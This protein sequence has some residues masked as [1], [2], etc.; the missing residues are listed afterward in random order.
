MKE[1]YLWDKTGAADADVR[2]LEALLGGLRYEPRPLALPA[3][4]APAAARREAQ[5]FP[6]LRLAAVAALALLALA[7][8]LWLTLRR[9]AP[10][11]PE[12]HVAE[13]KGGQP[14][15]PDVKPAPRQAETGGPAAQRAKNSA[16]PQKAQHRSHGRRTPQPRASEFDY[17]ASA[18]EGERAKEQLLLA[19]HVASEKLNAAQ[20]KIRQPGEPQS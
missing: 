18:A 9:H 2:E 10:A 16:P 5:R 1:D 13:Q 11:T 4:V 17:A 7:A 12:Q 8:T 15:A 19:L 14:A 20:K 6:A 3:K